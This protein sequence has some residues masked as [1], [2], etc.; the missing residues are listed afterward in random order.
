MYTGA[1]DWSAP[2]AP[3]A[4]RTAAGTMRQYIKSWITCWD[5]L[6]LDGAVAQIVTGTLGMNYGES[7]DF[8]PPPDVEDEPD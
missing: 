4:T 8:S 3:L 2:P 6:R 5:L 1:Y 7:G